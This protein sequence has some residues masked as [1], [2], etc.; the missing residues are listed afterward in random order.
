MRERETRAP[1]AVLASCR[2]SWLLPLQRK[3]GRGGAG[4]AR[5]HVTCMYAAGVVI[6]ATARHQTQIQ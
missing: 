3:A 1:H 6:A 5:A 4:Q 2:S